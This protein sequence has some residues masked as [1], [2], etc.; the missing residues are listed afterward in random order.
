[1][2]SRIS[3][4]RSKRRNLHSKSRGS[5]NDTE[6]SCRNLGCAGVISHQALKGGLHPRGDYSVVIDAG[7]SALLEIGL[8]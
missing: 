5:L 1:M 3:G 6:I 7:A 4:S 2:S 8:L